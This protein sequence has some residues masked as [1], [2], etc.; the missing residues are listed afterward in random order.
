MVC[1]YGDY[2]DVQA[3]CELGL[4]EIIAIGQDGR[5]LPGAG[6]LLQGCGQNRLGT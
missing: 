6:K 1:S 2:N 3:F 5:M 4:K